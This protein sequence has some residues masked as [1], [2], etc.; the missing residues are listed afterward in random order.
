VNENVARNIHLELHMEISRTS[1]LVR[2]V[3]AFTID[4]LVILILCLGMLEANLAFDGLRDGL[5]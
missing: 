4:K 1:L 2:R 5:K 3:G